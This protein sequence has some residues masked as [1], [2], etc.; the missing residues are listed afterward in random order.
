M[1]MVGSLT[2]CVRARGD[3]G[4]V[5]GWNVVSLVAGFVLALGA[6]AGADDH[7]S[8]LDVRDHDL[9]LDNR[10]PGVPAWHGLK[11]EDQ[12]VDRLSE[13]SN[14]ATDRVDVLCHDM[15]GLHVDARSQR[16]RLHVGGGDS[17]Y[18][19]LRVDSD[20][21]FVDGKA[22]VQARLQLALAGHVMDVHLPDFDLSTDSYHGTQMV[23]V[24]V[25]LIE[26]RF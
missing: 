11:L 1:L 14:R 21:H 4:G 5:R 18:L 19:S 9:T 22:R 20:W 12:I 6:T 13:I 8:M 3:H 16:A 17:H 2:D 24:N 23:D 25:P 26:R 7:V 10:W 15:I